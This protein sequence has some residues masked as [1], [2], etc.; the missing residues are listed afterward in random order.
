MLDEATA[1]PSATQLTPAQS[2][3]PWKVWAVVFFSLLTLLFG[4]YSWAKDHRAYSTEGYL[5]SAWMLVLLLPAIFYTV[6]ALAGHHAA[7]ATT[8]LVALICAM[9]YRWLGFA[10]TRFWS[11]AFPY[12]DWVF[13]PYAPTPS[14]TWFPAALW[15]PPVIPHERLVF[16]LLLTIG[17]ALLLWASR[18]RLTHRWFGEHSAW[19][20]ATIAFLLIVLQSWLHLS[21]RA[22]Y[23]YHMYYA[24]HPPE[25]K[26]WIIPSTSGRPQVR[27]DQVPQPHA[28]WHLYLFHNYQGAVNRDYG[29]FRVCEEVFQ[30]V[31]PDQTTPIVRRLLIPYISSQFVCF[32]NPYYVSMFFNTAFW[33]AAVVAGFA[34]AR[35]LTDARIA[36]VFALLI[37][38]GCG[39][40]FFVNQPMGYLSG[41]AA[42]IVLIYLFEALLVAESGQ[43]N[44][45]LF[46]L[47]YGLGMLVSDLLP[48]APMFLL[49]GL[50]R[51]VPLRRSI[52]AVV[53]AC[54]IYAA[55]L[56]FFAYA[57]RVP[58]VLGNSELLTH[59]TTALASMTLDRFYILCLEFLNRFAMDLFHAF[60]ILPL[61][62]A[63]LALAFLR[64]RNLALA[65]AAMMLPAFLTIAALEFSGIIFMEWPMAA[66]PR[67]AYGAYPAIYLL[68]AI[69]LVQGSAR[70]FQKHPRVARSI[71]WIFLIAVFALNNLD[72]F[73][74]PATYYQFYFGMNE[75]GV[76]PFGEPHD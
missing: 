56:A 16:C 52:S 7:I 60:L 14:I 68:A 74:V 44:V 53:I 25:Q 55:T 30:G 8:A 46:G 75:S 48:L 43:Q 11:D 17:A 76:I 3:A 35:R 50:V 54:C 33:L 21:L 4:R 1:Q 45:W 27:I 9:P 72:V 66:L 31:P 57:A 34:V 62:P 36:V 38:T 47:V 67:F 37:A 42:E 10:G 22:P 61:L 32:F 15:G 13:V 2:R 29:W 23:S 71:P 5:A 65:I 41:Y 18:G 39:F 73:G 69:G 64:Q 63:L 40:V 51:G 28:W 20:V 24:E 26:A 59:P 70:I 19:T 49:Y 58:D 6:R 12:T